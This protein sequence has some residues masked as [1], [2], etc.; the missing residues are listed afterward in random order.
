MNLVNDLF[1]GV[2][3]VF[4]DLDDTLWDFWKEP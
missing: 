2:K 1:K 3:W 4:V